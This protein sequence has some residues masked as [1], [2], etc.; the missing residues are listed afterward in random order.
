MLM[1]V[2]AQAG[3]SV[4]IGRIL[5][6]VGVLIAVLVV[7]A[8]VLM[9]LRRRL[10]LP[11]QPPEVGMFEHLRR[12]R[13]EGSISPEEYDAI[14]RRVATRLSGRESEAPGESGRESRTD[15]R[16]SDVSERVDSSPERQPPID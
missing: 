16:G 1:F 8:I 7:L 13:E 2:L 9:A 6:W 12:M 10:L 15:S 11:D 14:R 5:L 4:A 3:Q